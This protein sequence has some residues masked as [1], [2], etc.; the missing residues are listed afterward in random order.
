MRLH[1]PQEMVLLPWP[2]ALLLMH[3]VDLVGD[4]TAFCANVCAWRYECVCECEGC[5]FYYINKAA[6]AFIED[7]TTNLPSGPTVSPQILL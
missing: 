6:S 3:L 7:S 4:K 1:L 2:R 5:C